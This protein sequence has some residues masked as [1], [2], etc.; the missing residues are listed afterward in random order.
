MPQVPIYNQRTSPDSI[1]P[2]P[3]AQGLTVDNSLG[4]ALGTMAGALDDVLVAKNQLDT[5]QAEQAFNQLREK[6]M[7]LTAGENGY[8]KSKS[9]DALFRSSGKSLQQEYTESFNKAADEI[10]QGLSSDFARKEFTKRRQLAGLEFKNGLLRHQL[11][12]VN[13]YQKQVFDGTLAVESRRAAYDYQNPTTVGIA[14]DR[15]THAAMLQ[16]EREGLPADAVD[17][18]MKDARSTVH[19]GV[20]TSAIDNRNVDY[21]EEYFK[22]HGQDLSANDLLK[23]R[24]ALTEEVRAQHALKT[25]DEVWNEYKDAFEP[26]E[27]SRLFHLQRGQESGNKQFDAKGN[28]IVSSA[29]A[30][31]I[32]QVMPETGPEAAKLAGLPWDKKRLYS[33]AKYNAALGEAYMKQQ[34]KN[35]NGDVAKA[36]AAYNAGPG[37][38]DKALKRAEK[39]GGSWLGYLPKE[40]QKYTASILARY[41]V[42]GGAPAKPTLQQ[43]EESVRAKVGDDPKQ[44]KA[45]LEQLKTR[46]D[47]EQKAV[48]QRHDEALAEGYRIIDSGQPFDSLPME[49]KQQIDPEDYSKLRTYS[50]SVARGTKVGTNWETYYKLMSNPEELVKTNLG[51]MKGQF[52]DTEFK[53]LVQTQQK[54]QGKDGAVKQTEILTKNQ[55]IKQ[56]LIQMG[57]DPTPT[58]ASQAKA[59]GEVT[60]QLE[61]NVHAE[62]SALGRKLKPEELD[63]QLAKLF[64][65]I[66]V[67]RWYGTG[68]KPAYK[69]GAE[70]TIVVPP[71]ER[72]KIVA[73]LTRANKPVT[74]QLIQGTYRRKLESG[75]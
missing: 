72:K 41:A 15:V 6:Q 73:A 52:A 23:Y 31:G 27:L 9:K 74:E 18:L 17:A 66:P 30:V 62:E 28:P 12:E 42:G 32:N 71:E 33:D 64:V 7:D 47:L 14:L 3:R 20:L 51:A 57:V 50:D 70:D 22:Q 38:V 46:V 10:S 39:E 11:Q 54:L 8:L 75:R 5:L 24:G 44:L 35:Y 29:G 58:T 63:K 19:A 55:R 25:S 13:Q 43:M 4:K 56:Y 40:T 1:G 65:Q 68:K 67:E 37:A 2:S 16:A 59:L 60:S 21:A 36:L 34:L 48:K 45:S 69:V 26:T 53:Q 61:A 49:L